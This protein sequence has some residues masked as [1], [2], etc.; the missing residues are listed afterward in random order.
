[1][2][3]AVAYTA[4]PV[5]ALLGGYLLE[6]SGSVRTIF[7]WAAAIEAVL[8]VVPVVG[9]AAKSRSRSPAAAEPG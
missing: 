8:L 5:G 9:W 4:L 3:R 7:G 2:T 1:M 6:R